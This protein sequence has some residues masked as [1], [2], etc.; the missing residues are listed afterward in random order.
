MVFLILNIIACGVL[1]AYSFTIDTDKGEKQLNSSIINIILFASSIFGLMAIT[2]ALCF[3]AP[4]QLALLFGRTTLMLMGWFSVKC[5]FYLLVFPDRQKTKPMKVVQW[6]L[7]LAA[8]YMVFFV[9]GSM[10]SISV[11]YEG[12]FQMTSGLVLGGKLGR[13]L[14]LTWLSLFLALYNF[15]VPLFVLIMAFVKSEHE[16]LSLVRQKIRLCCIGVLLSWLVFA[17]IH[18]ASTFQPMIQSLLPVCYL[19]EVM[20]FLYAKRQNEIW[21]RNIAFRSVVKFLM[22]FLLPSL[23][24]GLFFTLSWPLF[25]RSR[26][27]FILLFAVQCVVV[28]ALWHIGGQ[29]V[30]KKGIL[31]DSRYAYDF[32]NELTGINFD[33]EPKEIVRHLANLFKMYVDSSS[34][35]IL[36]DSG[37]GYF[38]T[39]YDSEDEDSHPSFDIDKECFDRL[40]NMQRQIVFRE[41]AEQNYSMVQI[42]DA[43]VSFFEASKSDAFILL[44]EG[45]HIIGI[46]ALGKKTSGN[47][48]NDYDFQ[49]F[50][51]LYSS[52]FVIGYYVKNIMNESVV[53]T[54]DREIKMSAQIITSIQENMDF[55][56][57]PKVDAGYLMVPAHNIGGEFVDMIRLTD[58]RYIYIIGALSGKGIAA[59][60]SM[61]IMKSITR[62]Y[63][64]ETSDFKKLI[65]KVNTFI[66]TCLPKGTFFAGTFGLVDFATDTMY[67]I[68]CGSAALFLYTRAYN[69]V[70]EIQGEGHILGFA[71]DIGPLLK[72]KKVK[73][74]PG[75][76]V[77]SCSDGLIDSRSLRGEKYGKARLQNEIMENTTY[78]ASRI[79]QFMYEELTKFTSKELEDDVTIFLLKY[80]TPEE[81]AAA[82]GGK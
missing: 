70:I 36:I 29:Y 62:T 17:F 40:L 60:M 25:S 47:P 7:N 27:L 13:D 73:L 11:S 72:V 69:N 1:I 77:F 68:N 26:V 43:L 67:Y 30:S 24:L 18:Y 54:V 50:S 76:I 34:M 6:V 21:D 16:K 74:A 55:I 38:E 35:R 49:V 61:V 45:H 79:S 5:C 8:L 33:G 3:F 28:L 75:D 2:L 63:L 12:K 9:P 31:R 37:D 10:T 41:F 66:R 78:P 19:P 44:S 71:K 14:Q 23:L 46:I 20:M 64:A 4:P 81:M 52:F 57:N 51:D 32:S 56:K 59:S 80:R 53:G 22:N 65:E 42:R 82:E 39:V 58:T 48:Y 15:V